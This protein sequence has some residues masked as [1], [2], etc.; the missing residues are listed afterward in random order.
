MPRMC[1]PPASVA[2]AGGSR[3]RSTQP[4]SVATPGHQGAVDYRVIERRRSRQRRA[5]VAAIAGHVAT[6]ERQVGAGRG[7]ASVA[8]L[9]LAWHGWDSG[10]ARK[11][12]RKTWRE[13]SAGDFRPRFAS[14]ACPRT[15]LGML[16]PWRG[17]GGAPRGKG[18]A[19]GGNLV[20]ISGLAAL[21]GPGQR[22]TRGARARRACGR[23]SGG[24]RGRA[25]I[26]AAGTLPPQLPAFA[27]LFSRPCVGSG[28]PHASSLVGGCGR[29]VA[30]VGAK[31]G[32]GAKI[33]ERNGCGN[34]LSR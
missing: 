3:C 22:G 7:W 17:R 27:A 29:R 6:R 25:F 8:S 1:S 15:N 9:S 11:N 33:C 12:S 16:P 18:V 10:G 24:K 34:A 5:R 14:L 23:L 20:A 32:D 4:A 19:G 31:D 21:A 13:R 30:R 26:D 2:T 28:Y